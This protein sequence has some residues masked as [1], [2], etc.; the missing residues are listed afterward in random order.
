M[1][2]YRGLLIHV[3]HYDPAWVPA[4][5]AEEPFCADTAVEIVEA[6]A[7]TGMNVLVVDLADGV[8]YGTHPEMKRHYSVA[9]EKLE[10]V[11]AR[12]ESLGIDVVPK[13][14]FSKSGRNLHDMWM[15]P[16]WDHTSWLK[17]LDEYYGV[18]GDLI[19]E[20]VEA[21][22]PREFFHIGMDEDHYRSLEQYV[23]TIE[24]LR[25]QVGAHGLRTVIWND[26]C[27]HEKTK[28]AQVHADKCRAA[29]ERLSKDIV[30]ILWAY[31]AAHPDVVKRVAERGFEV[32]GAPGGTPDQ[33][34]AWRAALQA[35]G[36][37]GMLMTRWIKCS[38]R[39]RGEMLDLINTC[40]PG[41]SA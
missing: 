30:Q 13:L 29:E 26:S 24:T 6:M 25:K 16:H 8:E 27:H 37:T 22:K 12:A 9:M 5:D 34:E 33:T 40:G 38:G 7:G 10:T 21:L 23:E 19:G 32:W 28:I 39:T 3:S 1:L 35:H 41:Y 2:K 36:G 4:K 20:T 18:A 31:N 11:A 14:N 17:N 15:R